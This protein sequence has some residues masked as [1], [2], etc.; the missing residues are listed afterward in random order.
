MFL[1]YAASGMEANWTGGFLRVGLV[2]SGKRQ[3]RHVVV[4]RSRVH[5]VLH[6]L[7]D[8]LGK[9]LGRRGSHPHDPL[10]SLQAKFRVL[11]LSLYYSA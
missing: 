10:D 5:E 9:I 1:F 11:R 4:F 3:R 6:T 2:S 7:Q 8:I